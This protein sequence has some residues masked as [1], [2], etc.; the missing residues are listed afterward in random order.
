M[1]RKIKFR[2]WNFDKKVYGFPDKITNGTSGNGAGGK[3]ALEQFT[4]LKDIHGQE[5]YEG[6]IIFFKYRDR[7]NQVRDFTGKV[8]FDTG[9][10]Y[11][12]YGAEYDNPPLLSNALSFYQIIFRAQYLKIIGNIHEDPELLE[13]KNETTS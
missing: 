6:D 7:N 5:I 4:G 11:A 3:I 1:S 13:G 10:F 8:V 2:V 12:T 9:S